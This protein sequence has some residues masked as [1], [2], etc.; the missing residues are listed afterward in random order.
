MRKA[1]ASG[2]LR[3]PLMTFCKKQRDVAWEFQKSD[4]LDGSFLTLAPSFQS[5]LLTMLALS[6]SSQE[7]QGRDEPTAD[8]IVEETK[9]SRGAWVAQGVKRLT[10]DSGSGHDLRVMRRSP[11][12]GS[13]L[14]RVCFRFSLSLSLCPL[15]TWHAHLLSLSP[16][17]K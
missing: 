13:L 7:N 2:T 4:R 12:R 1:T 17:N 14:S 9:G 16:L 3:S 5:W 8:V 10:L 11:V 15:H 6:L